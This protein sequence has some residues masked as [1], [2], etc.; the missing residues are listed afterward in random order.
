MALHVIQSHQIDVLVNAMLTHVQQPT[1]QPLAVLKPQHFVVPS[2]AVEVWLNE[3]L[4]EKKGISANTQF[5]HRIRA[6]QWEAYQWVLDT[7]RDEVRKANI[8]RIIMQWRIFQSLHTYVAEAHNPLPKSHAL[9]KLIQR[10]FESA[11]NLTGFEQ[12]FKKQN[13]LYWVADKVSRLFSNYMVYRGVCQKACVGQCQCQSNWLDLWGSGQ[14]LDLKKQI[15]MPRQFLDEDERLAAEK[16]AEFTLE[17]AEDIELWQRWLWQSMFHDDFVQMQKIDEDFW[18]ALGEPDAPTSAVKKLPQQ[19]VIFTLLDLPPSQLFFIRR[20]AQYIDIFILHYNPSQEYWADMVDPKWKAR[21]DARIKDRFIRQMQQR[22]KTVSDE[23]I[24]AY[25]QKYNGRFEDS[26]FDADMRESHH[27]LL[28]R[29]GKQAR[30]HFSLLSVLSS[31]EEGEWWDEFPEQEPY[32]LLSKVQSDVLNLAEPEAH[33]FE[34]VEQDDSIRIHVCHSSLRQ[35]EV[36]KDQLVYWLAQDES[37]QPHDILVLSPN[38]KDQEALIRSIF[39]PPPSERDLQQNKAQRQHQLSKDSVYLPIQIAGVS[40]LDANNAWHSVL[41]RIQLVQGRFSLEEFSDWLS[42]NATQQ[43]YGLDLNAIERITELL[44][45]AGFKRGLDEAHLKRSLSDNDQDYRFSLKFALDRLALGIAVPVHYTVQEVL[46]YSEVQTSDFPLICILLEI[47]EDFAVRRDWLILH[48]QGQVIS[49]EKWLATL[50][51]DLSEY[52]DAGVD[53]LAQVYM[54]VQKHN[55]M[56]TLASYF[57]E[58]SDQDLRYLSLPL[59]YLLQEISSQLEMQV[60]QA[61]PSGAVTFSQIGAIRP[62]PYK[63]IVMLNLDSGTFPNRDQQLPFD[64]MTMLKPQLGDRSRMDDE[65]GAFLDAVLLA[66][67]NV[68]L[69]YNGFD[70]NDGEVRDP[71]TVVQ[72]FVQHLSFIVQQ[73]TE[74]TEMLNMNGIDVP[75]HLASL[76]QF[77][78]LQPF[79]AQAFAHATPIRYQDQWYRVAAH[80]QETATPREAWFAEYPALEQDIQVLD[81]QQ[82]IVDVCFPAQAY[83]KAIGIDNVSTQ[84]AAAQQEPLLLSGLEKYAVRDFMWKFQAQE[85]PVQLLQNTLPVG[86]T[87]DATWKQSL[88]EQAFLRERLAAFS[89]E[90]TP[91]TQR[92]YRINQ[93][94]HI[95]IRVPN[96]ETTL[97]C[98][99]VAARASNKRTAQVWLEY[100]LW[101]AYANLGA[102]GQLLERVVICNNDIIHF[103][104]LSSDEAKKAVQAWI[105]FWRDAQQRPVLLPAELVLERNSKGKFQIEW[106]DEAPYEVVN[107]DSFSKIWKDTWASFIKESFL[108]HPDWGFILQDADSVPMLEAAFHQYSHQLYAALIACKQETHVGA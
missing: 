59:S 14:A 64:L 39:A 66:Q 73:N 10:I 38:L 30:D 71:S 47:Y 72:E 49:V 106:S 34:L 25:I 96:V 1:V 11:E 32:S 22:N 81:S 40:S 13:M 84:A 46:S 90:E 42:L 56:L 65:Q 24:Q 88:L 83:L 105:A 58:Q 21:M 102:S 5:H 82:W 43:R 36:L 48:E 44:T 108:R 20:L 33:A 60:E 103:K 95:N 107:M 12:Q 94:L 67:E 9:Y 86:K 92:T 27:P 79:E 17:Q 99:V 16:I 104:G 29:F 26:G 8:P 100:I 89:D 78:A 55:R 6:F 45:T 68:W 69:F 19:L 91:T 98:N 52:M 15:Y 31:G 23:D 76:Y 62:L 63:L 50:M 80:M 41:G 51:Q 4:A 74:Q 57:E 28:T 2:K 18:H 75:A 54:I 61:S 7:Q 37:R 101:L 87:R 77:H 93:Q 85:T 70:V 97:W 35:L 3:R 53:V